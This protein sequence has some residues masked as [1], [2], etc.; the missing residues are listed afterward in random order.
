[1]PV[2]RNLDLVLLEA[3]PQ[4]FDP[5]AI[6]TALAAQPGVIEVHDLHVWEV[7]T[8]FPAVAAHV[9]VAPNEDCHARRRELQHLLGARFDIRHT[10]LQVDHAAAPQGLLTIDGPGG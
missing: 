8:G 9:V 1:M 2:L 10:T 3:A 4:G 7:T 5:Q 6:G